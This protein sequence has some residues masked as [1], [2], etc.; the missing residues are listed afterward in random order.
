MAE[1]TVDRERDAIIVVDLQPD[2]MPGG[3]LP[4]AGG[5]AVVTPIA[6]LLRQGLV[7]TVVATQ[8]WHPEGHISFASSHAGRGP[9]ETVEIHGGQAQTLWPDHCVQGTAG[10]E[11]HAAL[12]L[13]PISAIV[14]KGQE[15][16]IDSYSAFRDNLGPRNLRK[17]TGLSGYLR[18]RGIRRALLCGLALD[19]C[20]A[21][22]AFDAV[23]MDFQAVLLRDLAR[24][25]STAGE[26]DALDKLTRAG[27]TVAE[28]RDLRAGP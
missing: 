13:E 25:V 10:A 6:A 11:L 7:R 27:V 1:L 3:A 9:G 23:E 16:A 24:P 18:A 12:P 5:D 8:D 17:E 20:V 4:I 22:T 19:V 21:W 14:R 2:F 15:Q 26:R 28:S